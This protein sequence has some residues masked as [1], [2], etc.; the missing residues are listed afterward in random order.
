MVPD[1]ELIKEIE[2]LARSEN[3]IHALQAV[4]AE[5]SLTSHELRERLDVSRTTVKRNLDDLT[6]RGWLQ[7]TN[8]EYTITPCGELVATEF[9]ELVDAIRTI[10]NLEPV[11]QWIDIDF[12]LYELGDADVTAHSGRPVPPVNNHVEALETANVESAIEASMGGAVRTETLKAFP[13]EEIEDIID[14]LST[15]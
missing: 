6:E 2:F 10:R 13:E 12:N 3:R 15:T 14:N 4:A 7:N 8:N 11:M 5:K 9:A 1:S